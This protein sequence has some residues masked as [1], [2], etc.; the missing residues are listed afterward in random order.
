MRRALHPGVLAAAALIPSAIWL[1]PALLGRQALS[2]RDQADFFFPLKLYT[3]DRLRAFEIPL[4]NPWSGAGEP[5]LANA[6][7]GVFYPPTFLFLLPWPGLAAGLF[8]LLHFAVAAWG[9]W[10]FCRDEGVTAPGALLAATVFAGSGLAASLSAFW[11]HFGAFAWIPAIL[12]LARSGLR[13]RAAGAACAL[14]IGLQAMA[15]SPELSAATIL[16]TLMFVRAR[17]A[18]PPSGWRETSPAGSLRRGFAAAGLGLCLAAWALLPM[19]ELAIHSQ[20]RAPFLADV[21]EMGAVRAGAV[22]SLLGAGEDP[23]GNFFFA[24]LFLG[25]IPLAAAAAAFAERQRRS[26]AWL[27]AA[28][29]ALGILFAAAGPPGSWL[30]ELPGLDRV[31][32]PAKALTVSLFSLAALSGLGL[33]ALRFLSGRRARFLLAL[34]AGGGGLAVLALSRQP[35]TVRV[36]T[37]AGLVALLLLA[38]LRPAA[39]AAGAALSGLVALAVAV[40]FSSANRAVFRFVPAEEIRRLPAAAP[41]LT[42]LPG[43]VLTPTMAELAPWVTRDWT[44]DAATVRRQREALLG[45]TNLLSGVRTIRTASALPTEGARRIADAIDAGPDPARAAG[46][47]SGRTFWTP[48]PLQGGM[49]SDGRLQR[50][51][52]EPY[53]PRISLVGQYEI[54]PDPERAWSRAALGKSD[55]SRRVLLDREPSPRPQPAAGRYVIARIAEESAERVVAG[56]SSDT[57]GILVLTDLA[58]PGWKATLDGRPAELLTADGLFRAVAVPAGD[59]EVEFRYRPLS[60]FAGAAISVGAAVALLAW[61]RRRPGHAAES[62]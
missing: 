50:A 42:R 6:Q 29:G 24:S 48:F 34:A 17:R 7:A 25:P 23:A 36:A 3:A 35:A 39:P 13:S 37:G 44:F 10:R 9:M 53:R 4:W 11:N 40:S 47:A 55:W 58:Y 59:H 14:L 30:R 46:A 21:R 28:V 27:L 38:W 43:R 2:F 60:F 45:Y 22:A 54:E 5:W 51:S 41:L 56:V 26:L 33:D 32:Y 8:L 15:G 19:A 62:P 57:A 20:R 61:I 31:R 52:I 49:P 16:L 1:A 12:W 18:E